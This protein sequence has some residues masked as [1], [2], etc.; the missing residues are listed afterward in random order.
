MC[1]LI[2]SDSDNGMAVAGIAPQCTLMP[3]KVLDNNGVGRGDWIAG[4]IY[5]AVFRGAR[6]IV[7]AANSRVF[8]RTVQDAVNHA[9]GRGIPVVCPAGNDGV[10]LDADPGATWLYANT[11]VVSSTT[12]R[13]RRSSFSNYGAPV[14]FAAPGGD[15][16]DYIWAQTFEAFENG[17]PFG[18][19]PNS[20]AGRTGTSIAAGHVAGVLALAMAAGRDLSDVIATA[21]DMGT[22]GRDPVFG[23]G[24]PDAAAAVGAGAGSGAP[25]GSDAESPFDVAVTQ[26]LPPSGTVTV[27]STVQVFVTAANYGQF[28]DEF[29]VRL[30][31]NKTNALVGEKTVGIDAGTQ[32][33]VPL[34]R[35]PTRSAAAHS[36]ASRS[37]SWTTACRPWTP[38]SALSSRA[39]TMRS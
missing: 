7:I 10:N 12:S 27:G 8:S 28:Y 34:A 30:Y 13:G 16:L 36:S 17:S 18:M 5:E 1:S 11:V 14:M 6:V 26:I 39:R 25:G 32:T 15:F 20:I 3:C 2:G 9:A 24:I 35:P 33:D 23:Y 19:Q 38:R 29:K 37:R 4:G 21:R 31:D 22:V